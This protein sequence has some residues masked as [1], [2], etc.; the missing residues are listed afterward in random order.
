[1]LL[2]IPTLSASPLAVPPQSADGRLQQRSTAW[3]WPP[4]MEPCH[5]DHLGNRT[6]TNSVTNCSSIYGAPGTTQATTSSTRKT[7]T[8][9][10]HIGAPGR[11]DTAL[12]HDASHADVNNGESSKISFFPSFTDLLI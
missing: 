1:M 2:T 6:A 5:A 4:P 8:P 3:P 12:H 7:P 11:P 10:S 9:P